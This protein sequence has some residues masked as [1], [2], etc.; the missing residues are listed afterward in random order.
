MEN[1]GTK[2]WGHTLQKGCFSGLSWGLSI[3]RRIVMPQL[4]CDVLIEGSPD[5][6]TSH[7]HRRMRTWS[8]EDGRPN[9]KTFRDRAPR[10]ETNFS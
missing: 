10:V 4:M 6:D 3:S 1:M 9:Q 8:L 5:A 7:T 2:T